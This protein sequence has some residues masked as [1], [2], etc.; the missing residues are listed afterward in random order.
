MSGENAKISPDV[1]AKILRADLH[2]TVA[3]VAAGGSLRAGDRGR[4]E[5]AAL[6]APTIEELAQLKTRRQAALIRKWATGGKITR[7]EMAEIQPILPPDILAA[8]P[9]VDGPPSSRLK[10]NRDY[11]S[12]GAQIGVSER[13]IKRWA[14]EGKKVGEL[15]PLDDLANALN[16]WARH[17]KNSPPAE[18]VNAA[19]AAAKRGATPSE[20]ATAP[21][22]AAPAGN[23]GQPKT[24]AGGAEKPEDSTPLIDRGSMAVISLEENLQRISKQHRANLDLLDRA[25]GGSNEAE[26]TSRQRN[27]RLSGEMLKDAQKS[28]DEY[29]RARGDVVLI[30]EVKAEGFRVHSAMAQSLLGVVIEMGVTRERAA[31]GL[32][33]WY[34]QLRES[35]FFAD[36]APVIEA[37]ATPV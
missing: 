11:I 1:A 5:D 4:F 14:A 30:S 24:G 6:S 33:A 37:P 25:F 16:W 21:A 7:E 12:Y 18:L 35:R 3:K 8:P 27:A 34:R 36:T 2:N 13:T 32:N 26:I 29:Q 17:K 20:A 15:F 28:L 10:Y 23:R 9:V 19:S 22:T 31:I